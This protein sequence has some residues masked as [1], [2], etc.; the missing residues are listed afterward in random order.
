MKR[1]LDISILLLVFLGCSK[2]E[3]EQPSDPS[4]IALSSC[5]TRATAETA[6]STELDSPLFIFWKASKF[7]AD[8]QDLAVPFI[9]Q[10]P[11]GKIDD[12]QESQY[13]TFVSYP[14]DDEL[15]YASGFWPAPV[16]SG[17]GLT[18]SA[19]NNYTSFDVPDEWVGKKDILVVRDVRTGRKSAHFSV[20]EPL[21]FIHS[22]AQISINAKLASNMSKYVKNVRVEFTNASRPERLVWNQLAGRYI[23]EGGRTS[24]RLVTDAGDTEEFQLSKDRTQHVDNIFIVPTSANHVTVNIKFWMADDAD[25]FQKGIYTEEESGDMD[26]YFVDGDNNYINLGA[27]DSYYLTLEFGVSYIYLYG[28]LK[29]WEDGGYVTIPIKIS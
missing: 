2:T 15:I 26:I 3:T 27:G 1:M 23:L 5:L 13:N 9:A 19:S 7:D 10:T 6:E 17:T 28:R 14:T 29:A 8:P 25:G 20:L 16:T 12:Y 22:Q 24:S 11:S 4:T 21:Q 18:F